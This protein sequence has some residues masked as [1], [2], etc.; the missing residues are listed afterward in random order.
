MKKRLIISLGVVGLMFGSAGIAGASIFCTCFA[1]ESWTPVTDSNG[2]TYYHCA[3]GGGP[4]GKGSGVSCKPYTS[5]S[6]PTGYKLSGMSGELNSGSSSGGVFGMTLCLRGFQQALKNDSSKCP[7]VQ[8]TNWKQFRN[9]TNF[10]TE[11][12]FS[13]NAY[14]CFQQCTQSGTDCGP[15][16]LGFSSLHPK[17]CPN[18]PSGLATAQECGVCYYGLDYQ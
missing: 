9:Q 12:G 3:G 5:G 4:T 2:N 1:G 18:Q 16:M 6:K 15:L 8:P 17:Q 13:A 10:Y 7:Y 14:T 11:F